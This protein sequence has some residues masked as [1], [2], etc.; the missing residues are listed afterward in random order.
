M[1]ANANNSPTDNMLLCTAQPAVR[2]WSLER[3]PRGAVSFR[4]HKHPSINQLI[5]MIMTARAASCVDE[6]WPI[7]EPLLLVTNQQLR[8][9]GQNILDFKESLY[10]YSALQP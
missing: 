5:E 10:Y 9:N 3:W 2:C 8:Q 4:S 6:G 1:H 7:S